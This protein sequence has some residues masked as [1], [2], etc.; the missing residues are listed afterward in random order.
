ML[1][2]LKPTKNL[3]H[4]EK[5]TLTGVGPHLSFG[6]AMAEN[7]LNVKIGLVLCAVDGIKLYNNPNLAASSFRTNN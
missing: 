2:I 1:C 5:P 6:I 7:N 3:V 4:F